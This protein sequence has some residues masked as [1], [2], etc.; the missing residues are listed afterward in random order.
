VAEA[1][2]RARGHARR[3]GEAALWG[4]L[5]AAHF[6]C[7]P[8]LFVAAALGMSLA[9]VTQGDALAAVQDQLEPASS[10]QRWLMVRVGLAAPEAASFEIIMRPLTYALAA[11]FVLG[12]A[13]A[14]P[15]ALA[16]RR[17]AI[18]TGDEQGVARGRRL[19]LF[20][21]LGSTGVVALVGLVGWLVI[22]LAPS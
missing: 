15:W 7:Y 13:G 22:F 2:D 6:A 18:G 11:I 21:A 1:D 5:A 12:H 20:V 3:R 14:L 4:R 16:A 19:W 8:L 17:V 10:L 9:I